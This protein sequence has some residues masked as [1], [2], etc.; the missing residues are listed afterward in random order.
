MECANR[1]GGTVVLQQQGSSKQ[2]QSGRSGQQGT[3]TNADDDGDSDSSEPDPTL[4]QG[5]SKS[6]PGSGQSR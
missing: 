5:D 6:N 2:E 3:G 1:R 4:Q